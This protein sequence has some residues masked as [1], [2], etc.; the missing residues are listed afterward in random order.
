MVLFAKCKVT[1]TFYFC[2]ARS[3]DSEEGKNEERKISLMLA[4]NSD[5]P[6]PKVII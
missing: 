1:K 2:H 6:N 4:S 5:Q 3:N